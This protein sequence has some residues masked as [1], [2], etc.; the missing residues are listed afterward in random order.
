M[1][2]LDLLVEQTIAKINAVKDVKIQY[3][4]VSGDGVVKDWADGVVPA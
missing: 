3:P 4:I 2:G 1:E